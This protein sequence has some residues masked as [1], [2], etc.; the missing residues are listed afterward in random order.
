MEEKVG[1]ELKILEIYIDMKYFLLVLLASV[2][3]CQ[4]D[5]I[6]P[7]DFDDNPPKFPS[8]ALPSFS[9]SDNIT[10][11][12]TEIFNGLVRGYRIQVMIS[13]NENELISLKTNLEKLI[14][15]KVYI[16][17]ELPNYKL[18]VGDFINRKEAENIQKKIVQLGYRTA[19]VVP[20]LIEADI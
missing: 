5:F 16:I 6:K 4:S 14:D 20:T 10:S 7:S 12:S 2:G 17:F 15:Q 9:S 11:D 3:M 1:L 18:R 19:W 8:V 13:Q